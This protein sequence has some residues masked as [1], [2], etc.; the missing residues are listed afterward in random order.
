MENN[1]LLNIVQQGFR[2]VIGATAEAIETLQDNQKRSQVLSDLNAQWQEKSQV[3][4]E[5]GTMTE[6]EAKKIIEQFFKGYNDKNQSPQNIEI[7]LENNQNG[8]ITELINEI[9]TL[10][11]ELQN[12]NESK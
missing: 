5:K 10:R 8:S 12:L 2:T 11:E 3:W 4:S 6:Q 9:I 1:T 7:T